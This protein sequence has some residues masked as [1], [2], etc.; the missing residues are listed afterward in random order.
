MIQKRKKEYYCVSLSP[1]ELL[2]YHNGEV[3]NQQ[4]FLS[5]S[6]G[7]WEAQD[8]DQE[9]MP[10]EVSFPIHSWLSSRGVHQWQRGNGDFWGLFYKDTDS[11]HEG[12]TLV[13]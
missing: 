12:F 3:Y 1:F 6:A 2:K 7:G 10:G 13:T 5:H 8:Q 9:P 4:K 11:I